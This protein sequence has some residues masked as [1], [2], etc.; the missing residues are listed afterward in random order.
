MSARLRRCYAFTLIELLVVIAIIAVL[1]ALLLPAVQQAREAARRTQ[2]KNNMKQIGLAL[3][4]YHDVANCFPPASCFESYSMGGTTMWV[5]IMPYIDQA[6]VWNR[7]NHNR[8]LY[9]VSRTDPD[10]VA[11]N[12]IIPIYYCPSTNATKTY[13]YF[14]YAGTS[15]SAND[16]GMVEYMMIGGSDRCPAG[17]FGFPSPQ[18]AGQ[19]DPLIVQRGSAGP[20]SGLGTFLYTRCHKN[21]AIIRISSIKDGTSNTMGI[22][23]YSGTTTGQN[24]TVY[25]G[26][27]DDAPGPYILA[28]N[29]AGSSDRGCGFNYLV[30]TI[31]PP[32]NARWFYNSHMSN[33]DVRNV[34]G[35]FHTAA[36]HSQHTG[37]IHILLMDGSARF[38]SENVD[39][40]TY[41]NL[42]DRDDKQTL[43]EF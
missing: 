26:Y 20:I 2:C 23:E 21:Q 9:N 12:A 17:S 30:R 24:L 33:G 5:H 16:H 3:H 36:L 4:N 43:G 1:I 25:G 22:G 32:P 15:F 39:L 37:G 6:N 42:A 29:F 13:N 14:G 38:L 41:K 11:A 19:C 8:Y 7:V 40:N 31:G 28:E 10:A 18:P 27:G 35:P 34:V